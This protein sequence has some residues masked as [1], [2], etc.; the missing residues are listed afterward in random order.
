MELGTG[1]EK[2]KNLFLR[3]GSLLRDGVRVRHDLHIDT[4]GLKVKSQFSF[5]PLRPIARQRS[6]LIG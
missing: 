3:N 2:L 1:R 4:K 6:W 5:C